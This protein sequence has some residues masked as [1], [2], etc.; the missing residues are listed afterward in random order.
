M[1]IT[2]L[3]NRLQDLKKTL[4][5]VSEGLLS[6]T[7]YAII[8][9]EMVISAGLMRQNISHR[10]EF[11]DL[12]ATVVKECTFLAECAERISVAVEE[13]NLVH[14][15]ALR[16]KNLFHNQHN[17]AVS[18]PSE[19]ISEFFEWG[20]PSIIPPT[21]PFDFPFDTEYLYTLT[22]VCQKWRDVALETPSLWG[23]FRCDPAG[24][25]P[26]RWTLPFEN[27][28]LRLLFS[29]H[30]PLK[31][32][33]VFETHNPGCDVPI[34][35]LL[36]SHLHR[37]EY[38]NITICSDFPLQAALL[39][40]EFPVLSSLRLRILSDRGFLD[41]THAIVP[42]PKLKHVYLD[43]SKSRAS[44]LPT[45]YARL[46]LS[47]T[48]LHIILATSQKFELLGILEQAPQ[49]EELELI[50][51]VAQYA[52]QRE[53]EGSLVLPRLRSLT[54]SC[55][56]GLDFSR[57]QFPLLETLSIDD[58]EF[59]EF[60]LI[61]TRSAP[62]LRHICSWSY[63][64]SHDIIATFG[65]H[66]T[67]QSLDL[68]V[69]SESLPLLPSLL[70]GANQYASDAVCTTWKQLR[71]LALLIT[72]PLADRNNPHIQALVT[73]IGSRPALTFTAKIRRGDT[74][75]SEWIEET[76]GLLGPQ[77]SWVYAD[78]VVLY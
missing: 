54:Y 3:E 46:A 69:D 11:P 31:V 37:L 55:Q 12:L 51:Q 49:L 39:S 18:L 47:A 1:D 13:A 65:H 28:R 32:N 38:L 73:A 42:P 9:F 16:R 48:F 22:S 53:T 8:F 4:D 77:F 57:I 50:E 2:F 36:R 67:A 6:S 58:S 59:L 10:K 63:L 41:T 74:K 19:I 44:A 70:A 27:I 40:A 68:V 25:N 23:C 78:G 14:K 71:S 5:K 60:P 21:D 33:L 7:E 43:F 52:W 62:K 30:T 45:Y 35:P 66:A 76:K 17:S 72:P 15:R 26:E 29:K 61:S 75:A 64:T 34:L 56:N 24:L 20:L